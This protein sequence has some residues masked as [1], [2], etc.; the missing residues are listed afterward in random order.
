MTYNF[1]LQLLPTSQIP[2][3]KLD[4]VPTK[5]RQIFFCDVCFVCVKF[6]CLP[7]EAFRFGT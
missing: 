4:T 6:T 2:V 3:L 7:L 1:I 5:S